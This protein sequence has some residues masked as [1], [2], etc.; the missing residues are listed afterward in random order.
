MNNNPLAYVVCSHEWSFLEGEKRHSHTLKAGRHLFPFQ[1][2]IGGSLPSSISTTVFGGASVIY[3]LRAVAVRP[4]LAS[5]LQALIP[6]TI[7]RSFAAEALEYQQTL[8]IENTWPEKLMYS[9]MIP[10]KAWAAGDQL[11]ALVKFSPLAKGAHVASVSTTIN[12]TTKLFIRGG[13]QEHTRAV[14]SAKH[15]IVN[16]RAVPI[17][18]QH[19]RYR[20]GIFNTAPSVHHSPVSQ[21]MPS[22][23]AQLITSGSQPTNYF[24]PI[25]ASASSPSNVS[26]PSHAH[27]SP[28]PSLA[29]SSSS[30]DNVDANSGL[31]LESEMNQNDVVT[32]LT[33]T[34][35][36]TA[37]PSHALEPIIVSHRIRWSILIANLDG[38]TSELRCS[39]PVYLL[40]Y[41]LIDE[42]RSATAATRRLLLGG[43]EVP[44]EEEDDMEL[45]SYPAHVRDRVANM[46][47]PEAATMRVTNPWVQS[48]VSP[49]TH[50]PHHPHQRRH[51]FS[52]ST[53]PSGASSPLEAHPVSSA[54]P[55]APNSGSSTP[56]DW[57][58]SELL[59]SLSQEAPPALR[60]NRHS[61]PDS[62][63]SSRPGS[64]A[65]SNHASRRQSR[66][67]SPERHAPGAASPPVGPNETYVHGG[68]NASRNLHGIFHMSMKP[69]TSITHGGWLS[70]RSNS[71]S[72]ISN[73]AVEAQQRQQQQFQ[74][75]T[76][77]S[78]GVASSPPQDPNSSSALLHRAFTEVP[79]YGIASR[80]FIGGVPPLSSMTGLPSYEEAERSQSDTDL[81]ARFGQGDHPGVG[82][83]TPA[84][85]PSTPGL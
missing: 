36:L 56:L 85:L 78:I 6:V 80:G 83:M 43:P 2:Q 53:V 17:E 33:V 10:H 22:T 51:Y 68:S 63:P 65:H 5:N 54:L 57:V 62:S 48:N 67:P 14:A 49:I 21:S 20:V 82:A 59:L 50:T 28:G 41:R 75:N 81:A 3:K 13:Y 24:D 61:P 31:T 30:V 8:E 1:L 11:T 7:I 26:L 40:D 38:H 37:T 70:S 18:E 64:A 15:D 19:H 35:P 42:A 71:H 52:L 77:P 29:P 23:P 47:L 69:F 9:I 16:G 44:P 79:D 45:P 46:Y 55:H 12:E 27:S 4:G 66:A 72:N 39:L 58:N 76:R 73:L 32:H 34:V 60:T 25:L 74:A 84:S